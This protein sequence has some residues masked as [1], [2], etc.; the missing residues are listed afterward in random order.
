M[1]TE[2]PAWRLEVSAECIASGMCLGS[3]SAYFGRA[4]SG[5]SEPIRAEI[6]PS[7]AVL[8]AAASCPVEAIIV[9]DAATGERIEP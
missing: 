7:E 3:A 4:P 1:V 6:E 8:D 9:R 2:P 5:R